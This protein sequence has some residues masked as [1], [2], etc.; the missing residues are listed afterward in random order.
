MRMPHS[1]TFAG[2]RSMMPSQCSR[3]RIYR[4]CLSR[5]A[6][7]AAVCTLTLCSIVGT[8]ANGQVLSAPAPEQGREDSPAVNGGSASTALSG[9]G[10]YS[11]GGLDVSTG[12]ANQAA[13]TALSADQI[14]NILQQ[15][16]DLVLEL[17]SQLA[18][19]MQQ[20]GVQIDPNDISDQMLYK[21]IAASADLRANIT[22]VLRARGY[23][24]DSNLQPSGSSLMEQEEIN[25]QSPSQQSILLADSATAAGVD[26]GSTK[27]E[28][29][30]GFGASDSSA[31]AAESMHSNRNRLSQRE[32]P[33]GQE[34]ANASTDVPRVLHQPSP[35][36]LQS[37]RDLYA[38]IPDETAGLKRFGSDVFVNRDVSAAARGV[39]ARDTPLDVPL[40]PDYI[41]GPGDTLTIHL[42]G[43]ITESITRFID[44]DGS[45]FL[46][47]A[48]SIDIAGLPLGK[49]QNVIEGVLTPQYRNA[50]VAVTVSHLR[51]VRVYVVGDVQR[52]GGYDI[53]SLST[54][55]SAL[56]IAGGP[57]ATGSLRTLLHYRGK[58]L[59]EDV[60]LYD[61]LLHGLRNSSA[62]F[63]SGDTLLVPPAGP[64]V[65]VF[66]AV[67]R[68]AIYEL[69]A[70]ESTLATVI[71]DAGGFTAA[72]SLGHIRIER[73][74][75]NHQR[76]TVTLHDAGDRSSQADHGAIATFPVKD[77]D[78]IRVEPILPYSQRAIYLSGHVVRPGRLA[79]T[80]G[81][82]LSDVLRSYQDMLPEPAALG[83]IVRLLPPDLH[84][85]TID[86]N[87]SD[88]L[89][90]NAN[91]DLHP[92]DTIRV[93]GR[94]QVDPPTVTICGEVRAPE[95]TP[96]PG[97]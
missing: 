46:P 42:W 4:A 6:C 36:D 88:V 21:Q 95:N 50:H 19:R 94:Y 27:G 48:G 38:Q 12:P 71:D 74:D 28:G 81:M 87:V 54:P 84:A 92:F 97:A 93:F 20:Q 49:A 91:V 40:G 55:L 11:G 76:E 24:A 82:R 69:K 30:P 62:P 34:N 45:I 44:R 79:Y 75:A 41:V 10:G 35:Y 16:P 53:S 8:H 39:S 73:I 32:N 25:P 18:D 29:L 52:P 15:S 57:T 43:G 22:T 83:E 47:E 17:K 90:G 68:P 96:C 23:V 67:K 72:A 66:G 5:S 37:M 9:N 1:V 58:Q 7:F 26:T 14:T 70:G 3:V 56:Y 65:A 63:E 64:L 60:D 33:R 51:S 61:F 85:E 78:R 59:V 2:L 80:D 13:H 86:F 89:T 31:T 77:G